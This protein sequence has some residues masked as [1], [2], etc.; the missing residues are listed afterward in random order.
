MRRL[1]FPAKE[2]S[3]ENTYPVSALLY[4][5]EDRLADEL[6]H[7]LRRCCRRVDR[8]DARSG[9]AP[10][11]TADVIFCPAE[12]DQVRHLK[13][14]NPGSAVIVAS[15][16]PEVSDWLDALEAGAADYCAAPFERS[17][18]CWVLESHMRAR[19]AA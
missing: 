9:G 19:P 11:R 1:T 14:A 15:R 7:V 4:G 8:A 3:V 2:I 12:V 16:L 17:Q 13:G 5:L 10:V 6:A 18:L